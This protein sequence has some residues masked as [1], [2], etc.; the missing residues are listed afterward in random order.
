MTTLGLA[1]C[2]GGVLSLAVLNAHNRRDDGRLRTL[3]CLAALGGLA[4]V[5]AA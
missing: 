1:L 2:L 4:L 5:A 3:A